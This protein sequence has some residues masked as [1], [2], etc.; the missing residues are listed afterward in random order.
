MNLMRRIKHC[1]SSRYLITIS[2]IF[3]STLLVINLLS[4]RLNETVLDFRF[5]YSTETV[6]SFLEK[7]DTSGRK[8]YTFL[9]QIDFVFPIIYMLFGV[10]VMS[11]L[12]K[13]Y[14]KADSFLDLLL[15]F[16]VI[17]MVCDWTEN[18]LL[19]KMVASYG[20][21]TVDLG[22][23]AATMTFSKLLLL[24]FF[25]VMLLVLSV[26]VLLKKHFITYE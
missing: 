20:K 9:L 4:S 2:I 3:G 15:F 13:K 14:Q 7:I 1:V 24:L 18:Y 8:L 19:L 6:Y 12:L 11:A 16:P 26:L 10:C 23:L 17:A 5:G 25:I 21:F 22:L